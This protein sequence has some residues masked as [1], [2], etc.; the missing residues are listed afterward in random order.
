M[1]LECCIIKFPSY[2]FKIN[3]K[4]ISRQNLDTKIKV[5]SLKNGSK[6]IFKKL[7]LLLFQPEAILLEGMRLFFF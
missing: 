3:R 7:T 2:N 4:N 1:S 6:A 5:Y